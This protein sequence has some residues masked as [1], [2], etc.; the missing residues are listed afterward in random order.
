MKK[1]KHLDAYPEK[2]Y[3]VSDLAWITL[4]ILSSFGGWG[5]ITMK[6]KEWM[7]SLTEKY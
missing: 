5:G 2:D 1:Q 3:S 6:T 7:G 4:N